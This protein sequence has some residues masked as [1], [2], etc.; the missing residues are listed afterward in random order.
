[1][2][3]FCLGFYVNFLF[4][5]LILVVR[6]AIIILAY[7]LNE[8]LKHGLLHLFYKGL[9]KK[10]VYT[11]F[12]SLVSISLV[13]SDMTNCSGILLFDM[14]KGKVYVRRNKRDKQL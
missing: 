3:V 13:V 1:M 6:C 7:V 8:F 12:L 4:S 5:F 11:L 14:F 2:T 10:M 9:M